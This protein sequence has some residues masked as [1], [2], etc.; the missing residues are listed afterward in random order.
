M[1]ISCEAHLLKVSIGP[2]RNSSMSLA[3]AEDILHSLWCHQVIERLVSM[4]LIVYWMLLID[5]SWPLI[6]QL[7]RRHEYN[8]LTTRTSFHM[9]E[10]DLV[11][12][13]DFQPYPKCW[14]LTCWIDWICQGRQFY[15]HR[16][17]FSW[18]AFPTCV[19]GWIPTTRIITY[20]DWIGY[21]AD[22]ESYGG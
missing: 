5:A 8:D 16:D 2:W 13:T 21:K 18:Y 1:V 17:P 20:T 22:Q 4:L 9:F 15:K 12:M 14:I 3:N 11:S 10:G 6:S 19:H 7:S